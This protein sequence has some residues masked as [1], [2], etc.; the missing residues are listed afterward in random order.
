MVYKYKSFIVK[1]AGG[2]RRW[3]GIDI[4]G[5]LKI[6]I[7][8]ASKRE[9][10]EVIDRLVKEK[11]ARAKAG[12]NPSKHDRRLVKIYNHIDAVYADKAGMPHKCDAECRRAGH[13]YVHKFKK[14]ASVYGRPDGSIEVRGRGR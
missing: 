13:R 7:Q 14:R 1:P 4:A 11:V 10:C 8:A 3:Q 2:G 6:K 12:G 9:V 5:R